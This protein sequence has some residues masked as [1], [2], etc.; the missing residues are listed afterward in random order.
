MIEKLNKEYEKTV[1]S[2]E[3][4]VKKTLELIEELSNV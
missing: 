4:A 2:K 1:W 3:E